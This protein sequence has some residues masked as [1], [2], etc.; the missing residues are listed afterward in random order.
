MGLALL[1][2]FS[3]FLIQ[4]ETPN[5]PIAQQ[6]TQLEQ[7]LL[8]A[9]LSLQKKDSDSEIDARTNTLVSG[10]LQK[11]RNH[12]LPAVREKL[13]SDGPGSKLFI[14]KLDQMEARFSALVNEY[15]LDRSECLA[16]V[17]EMNRLHALIRH[18]EK[19]LT[20]L[21]AIKRQ[22]FELYEVLRT[23]PQAPEQATFAARNFWLEL[24]HLIFRNNSPIH[25]DPEN[26]APKTLIDLMSFSE[27]TRAPQE[28]YALL[29]FSI[30]DFLSSHKDESI[31]TK[32][33]TLAQTMQPYLEKR[34]PSYRLRHRDFERIRNS[35]SPDIKY[36]FRLSADEGTK[37]LNI[38]LELI[39]LVYDAMG[40][41]YEF[42]R[43]VSSPKKDPENPTTAY[44]EATTLRKALEG[45]EQLNLF[46]RIVLRLII[47]DRDIYLDFRLNFAPDFKFTPM[48][49]YFPARSQHDP[50]ALTRSVRIHQELEDFGFVNRI[51]FA[52]DLSHFKL[53]KDVL[54]GKNA[55]GIPVPLGEDDSLALDDHRRTLNSLRLASSMEDVLLTKNDRDSKLLFQGNLQIRK[56]IN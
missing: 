17:D 13:N 24:G 54:A 47:K 32:W 38:Q 25:I 49:W 37:D 51:V 19:D 22:A 18:A 3:V 15:F 42:K 41:P 23:S 33:R 35:L 39:H 9:E 16:L 44:L 1:L 21:L 50:D 26:R 6:L 5:S 30:E 45:V 28:G 34:S 14:Q 29:F 46:G 10:Y 52:E 40:R 36:E 53:I 56:I 27:G 55:D 11:M 2:T 7:S 8:S 4:T 31:E 43:L 12:D 48:P 20:A